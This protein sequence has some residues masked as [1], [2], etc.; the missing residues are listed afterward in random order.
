MMLLSTAVFHRT[1][2]PA[3]GIVLVFCVDCRGYIQ[4][5]FKQVEKREEWIAAANHAVA[6]N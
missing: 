6:D 1:R 3:I 2:S 4:Y 5:I